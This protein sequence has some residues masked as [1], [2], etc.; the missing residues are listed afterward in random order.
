MLGGMFILIWSSTG[1]EVDQGWWNGE[2]KLAVTF[3]TMTGVLA[4]FIHPVAVDVVFVAW[5][6]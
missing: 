2:G 5:E 1:H 4:V 6:G 3:T